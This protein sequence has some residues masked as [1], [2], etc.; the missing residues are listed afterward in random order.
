MSALKQ[1]SNVLQPRGINHVAVELNIE[2]LISEYVTVKEVEWRINT[3]QG[4]EHI[5]GSTFRYIWRWQNY[6]QV[7]PTFFKQI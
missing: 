6:F 2:I 3:I 1:N 7:L 4:Q 5:Q